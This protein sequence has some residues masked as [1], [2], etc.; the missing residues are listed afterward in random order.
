MSKIDANRMQDL[1]GRVESLRR[2]LRSKGWKGRRA[3]RNINPDEVLDKIR[4]TSDGGIEPGFWDALGEEAKVNLYCELSRVLADL[5]AARRQ[6]E[7]CG[8]GAALIVT[9][10][11]L[12]GAAAVFTVILVLV[13]W[14]TDYSLVPVW[15]TVGAFAAWLVL[16]LLCCRLADAK[17]AIPSS[18]GELL[19]RLDELEAGL[20]SFCTGA[21]SPNN[22]CMNAAYSAAVKQH[23]E[24][25]RDL[26]VRGLPWVLAT[27]YS[28]VWE[29]LYRAEEA[30]IEFAPRKNVL[31]SALYD[32][33]RLEGSDVPNRDD[34]LAKL[35]KAVVSIDPSAHKYLK[36]TVV[37]TP[38]LALS[39]GTTAL[40]GATVA[41]EYSHSLLAIGGVPPYKWTV[42]GGAIPDALLLSTGGELRGTP[43]REGHASF[44]IRV[45]D[46]E[47][48]AAERHL[49]LRISPPTKAAPLAI[50]TTKPLP[51]GTV[52]VEYVE[53]LCATGGTPPYKW[54]FM[55][56]T[57][58]DEISPSDEGV[59][60]GTPTADKTYQFAVKV[61][62]S[63]GTS[64]SPVKFTLPIKPS[65][66]AASA[67][68]GGIQ[69]ELNARG[70]LSEVRRSINEYRNTRWTGLILARNRLLATFMLTGTIVFALLAIAVMSRASQEQIIAATVFYLVGAT[71]GLCNRLR[72]QSQAE[73]AIPDY[74]LSAARLITLPLFSGLGAIG[75]VLL[76]ACSPFASVV[77]PRPS[78]TPLAISTDA[79]LPKYTLNKPYKTTLLATGGT[80]PYKWAIFEPTKGAVP[81]GLELND[82]GVLSG[83]PSK[84]G[85]GDHFVA[86]VSDSDGSKLLQEFILQELKRRDGSSD[87]KPDQERKE[88]IGAGQKG[89]PNASQNKGGGP[90]KPTPTELE[91]KRGQEQKETVG[92]GQKGDPNALQN[93]GDGYAKPATNEKVRQTLP[94]LEDIFDLNKN[95][96]G[97]FVA[98]VFGLTPGLLFDRLQQ[99]ADRYKA[100]LKSSQTTES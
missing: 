54:E 76:I 28:K 2:T 49:D 41:E 25:R 68:V 44:A 77:G 90:G 62:D 70:V 84:A 23:N 31:E 42:I 6:M 94:K 19:P 14:P 71:V 88:T 29:R 22:P 75:G 35:R 58:L 46:S 43:E 100:D 21:G 67:P 56:G 12:P 64:T 3:L 55:D 83:T 85:Q 27:G 39:I 74:G 59:L 52:G 60:R 36:S 91:K 17:Y 66:A 16:S 9:S 50:S 82:A 89:D 78:S 96:I 4:R 72:N 15:G 37:V 79:N 95:L 13:R 45:T 86:R 92:T 48:V 98:A 11:F 93:K 61:T 57:A 69:Q 10:I 80:R 81:A 99:Q 7:A 5:D 63:S 30:M 1:V 8:Y 53:R 73:S 32:E 34:L 26:D 38:P 33:A 18:Y 47:G 20:K 87:K 97:L 24:I 40:P 51:S 65:T